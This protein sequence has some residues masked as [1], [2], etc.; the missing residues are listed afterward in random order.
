MFSVG[1]FLFLNRRRV[2]AR[3]V[4]FDGALYQSMSDDLHLEGMTQRTHDGYLRAVRKLAEFLKL[5]PDRINED[6]LRRYFLFIKNDKQF[7]PGSLRVAKSGIKFFYT[8][9]CRRD[10][11]TL[12]RLK[13]QNV[14]S[15]PEDITIE[16][17]HD[18]IGRS[19]V[20]RIAA[21]FWTLY[22]LGLPMSE[23]LNL[24]VLNRP[25]IAVRSPLNVAL[26]KSCGRE[27]GPQ[28]VG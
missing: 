14:K 26:D 21:Y 8:R 24:H 28:H 2:M 15:L 3:S 27:F 25:G 23:G 17:V 20:P 22:S 5:S 1:S 4:F 13:I 11:P 16:Q 12:S 19:R 6:R 7:A 18:L 10:W 9:T